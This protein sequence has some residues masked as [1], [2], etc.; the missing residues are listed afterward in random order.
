MKIVKFIFNFIY[1]TITFCLIFIAAATALSNLKLP[2]NGKLLIV[3]SGSMEPSIKTGSAVF[4][5]KQDTYNTDEII[6]FSGGNP[7]NETTTHRIVK[8]ELINGQEIFITKGDANQGEDR[9]QTKI[10]NIL[11]KVSFSLPYLGY[12]VAFT[13]TQMGFIFLIVVPA[14]I[15]IFS[16]VLNLKKEILQL[17][18]KRKQKKFSP[19]S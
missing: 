18:E 6:T 4:I 16:E 7:K 3:Q 9:E 19:A 10:T 17:I 15:I 5:Q 8:S 14:V 11:G 13:K 1:W 12:I 2:N